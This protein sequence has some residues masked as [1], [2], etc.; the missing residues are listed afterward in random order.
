MFLFFRYATYAKSLFQ[1]RAIQKKKDCLGV[2]NCLI[3]SIETE[4]G[5]R[6]FGDWSYI[7]RGERR[8]IMD[9]SKFSRA[10]RG[11]VN[12]KDGAGRVERDLSVD[13]SGIQRS[14]SGS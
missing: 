9:R 6:D 8:C 12:R 11:L 5:N 10:K 4:S 2:R 13:V 3:Y 7:E 1:N 14:Y